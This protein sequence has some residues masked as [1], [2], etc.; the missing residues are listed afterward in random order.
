MFRGTSEYISIDKSDGKMPSRR[1]DCEELMYPLFSL[2]QS[3]LPWEYLRGKIH[4][5]NCT[6]ICELKKKILSNNLLPD[7]P[8]A[9]LFVYKNIR[10]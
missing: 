10:N 8:K 9:F 5:K 3:Q 4:I 6:K 7:I 1:S 2:I